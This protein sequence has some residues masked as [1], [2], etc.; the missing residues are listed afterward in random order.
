MLYHSVTDPRSQNVEIKSRSVYQPNRNRWA[1]LAFCRSGMNI[2]VSY[3]LFVLGEEM[4]STTVDEAKKHTWVYFT[5]LGGLAMLTVLI[6]A[7][8]S[9]ELSVGL[10][11]SVAM[12]IAVS[13]GSLVASSFV[14]IISEK[15]VILIVLIFTFIFFVLLIVFS[16]TDSLDSGGVPNVP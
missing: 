16:L 7:V 11:V 15:R 4:E 2:P 14:H 13:K 8:A 9:L 5:V 10:A 3:Y 12:I 1:L 6:V